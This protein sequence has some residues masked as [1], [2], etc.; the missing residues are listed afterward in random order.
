M[1]CRY[2]PLYSTLVA[3]EEW[4]EL[5]NNHSDVCPAQASRLQSLFTTGYISL[6][7]SNA[8]FGI[9]LDTLGPRWTSVFGLAL[10]IVGNLCF[11]FGN[12]ISRG[13][14]AFFFGFSCI[15]AGGM[16]VFLST[17]QFANLFQRPALPCSIL[18]A[19]FNCSG[20][21]FAN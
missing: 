13:G 20:K 5:C 7:L 16:G 8:F 3:E 12:S 11:A 14:I 10:S 4:H 19:I 18:S 2:G 17:F 6:S 1:L 9:C 15:A 21:L